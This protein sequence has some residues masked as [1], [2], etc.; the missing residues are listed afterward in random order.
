ML[1]ATPKEVRD[2]VFEC[3]RDLLRLLRLLGP[4]RSLSYVSE[5]DLPWGG[6]RVSGGIRSG[7][8]HRFDQPTG[9]SAQYMEDQLQQV[10]TPVIF[11]LKECRDKH[12]MESLCSETMKHILNN[13]SAL[14]LSTR[15]DEDADKCIE[16]SSRRRHR[17]RDVEA[18]VSMCYLR[19]ALAYD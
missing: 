4:Q 19:C 5:S 1:L 7:T 12:G 3:W 2:W 6:G 11:S 16:L 18:R 14:H 8:V 10:I 9:P 15:R 13:C 17:V